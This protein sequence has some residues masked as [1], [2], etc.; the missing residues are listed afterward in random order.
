MTINILGQDYTV[1]FRSK[2]TDKI[3]EKI[4]GYADFY[5]KLIVI[6]NDRDGNIHDYEA[7]HRQC[8]RHE[9]IHAF[10]YESGLAYNSTPVESPWAMNEEMVD[11]F[12]IQGLKIYKAWQEAGAI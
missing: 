9:I 3:L 2:E 10:L 12:A 8:L 5:A 4:D 11:F 1:E 7:Y 6:N